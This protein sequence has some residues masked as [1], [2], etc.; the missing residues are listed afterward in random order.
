MTPERLRAAIAAHRRADSPADA[1]QPEYLPIGGLRHAAVLV[2]VFEKDGALHVLLTRRPDHL[3]RHPGQISFPGGR[4]DAEEDHLEAALRE[5][6]EEIGL[7]P[8]HVEV[9][10]RLSEAVVLTSPFRLTPWV[11]S[12][13]YPYPY[14]AAP[15]EVAEILHLPLADLAAPGVHHMETREAYGMWHQVHF[16]ALG[17]IRLWGATARVLAELVAIWRTL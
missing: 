9:V 15:G 2:P 6:Q 16:F 3:P 11:A 10:G 17:S 5:A 14:V 7:D 8:A 12:V 4:I 1:V 13:P